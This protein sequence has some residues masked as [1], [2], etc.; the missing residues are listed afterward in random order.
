MGVK[1]VGMLLVLCEGISAHCS[2]KQAEVLTE[3]VTS[4]TETKLVARKPT[5]IEPFQKKFDLNASA[6]HLRWLIV[7]HGLS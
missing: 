4:C 6:P 1:H 5:Q 7:V 2:R 3:G